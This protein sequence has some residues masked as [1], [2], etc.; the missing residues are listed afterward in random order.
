MTDI[1][2]EIH[3]RLSVLVGLAVSEVSHAADM[4]TLHFGALKQYTTRRGTVLEGGIWALHIQCN[5]EI[6]RSSAVVANQDNFFAS[7][8]EIN[9]TTKK[10]NDLLVTSGAAIVEGVVV[11]E[12]GGIC[13]SLSKGLRL[14]AT[15][16]GIQD[17]EDW[18]FFAPGDSVKPFILAGGGIDPYSLS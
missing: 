6:D 8:E 4:L 12:R 15:S 2:E 17:E 3:R 13:I 18:R 9:R 1:K 7:D 5:W 10:I 11:S 14:T 16:V